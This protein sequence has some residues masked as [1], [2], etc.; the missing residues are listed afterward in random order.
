M[1]KFMRKN[2][3]FISIFLC[4]VLLPMVT[5]S[6]M[7]IDVSRIQNARVLV[8]SAGDLAMNAGMSEY[9]KTLQEMYG[10][11]ATNTSS[12][13]LE[14]ALANYFAKTIQGSIGTNN[15]AE[16]EYIQKFSQKFMQEIFSG[17]VDSD[18]NLVG[19][20]GNKIE[21]TNFMQMVLD[22]Q[23]DASKNFEYSCVDNSSPANPAVMKQQIVDY[24]KYKG[25]VSIS[26]NLLNKIGAMKDAKKQSEAIEKKLDYTK[27]L[28]D[29]TD[30]C[31]SAFK[32]V[33]GKDTDFDEEESNKGYNDYVKTYNDD[34]IADNKPFNAG[35]KSDSTPYK[36]IVNNMEKMTEFALYYT[37]AMIASGQSEKPSG[38]AG[39]GYNMADAGLKGLKYGDFKNLMKNEYKDCESGN[40]SD[41]DSCCKIFD[42]LVTNETNPNP[43]YSFLDSRKDKNSDKDSFDVTFNE[44]EFDKFIKNVTVKV[45]TEKDTK[46]KLSWLEN[47]DAK[48]ISKATVKSVEV[49]K[50]DPNISKEMIQEW[51]NQIAEAAKNAQYEDV[52]KADGD[53]F[54]FILNILDNK[55][56]NKRKYKDILKFIY[57]KKQIYDLDKSFDKCW[58][59][60]E[61]S[62]IEEKKKALKEKDVERYDYENSDAA[63]TQCKDI[64][65]LKKELE[66]YDIQDLS[67]DYDNKLNDF[68]EKNGIY[69]NYCDLL[70]NIDSD[71]KNEKVESVKKDKIITKL[72]DII[73]K[74]DDST[75]RTELKDIGNDSFNNTADKLYQALEGKKTNWETA[76]TTAE[77]AKDKAQENLTNDKRDRN[78]KIDDIIDQGNIY[79]SRVE[80]S[81]KALEKDAELMA[82]NEKGYYDKQLKKDVVKELAKQLD[83]IDRELKDF[84]EDLSDRVKQFKE[85][86]KP[87]LKAA[88]EEIDDFY[89][90]VCKCYYFA[91]K[92]EEALNKVS[93]HYDK[94]EDK[95]QKWQN[96][97]N[98]VQDNTEKAKMVS[99]AESTS[100]GLKKDDIENAKTA[101]QNRKKYYAELKEMLESIRFFDEG[102]LIDSSKTYNFVVTDSYVTN[103]YDKI[104]EH[105]KQNGLGNVAQDRRKSEKI[106]ID[107]VDSKSKE[108]VVGLN[109]N[110][111]HLLDSRPGG[112]E[113]K[114]FN[115]N[116]DISLV[117]EDDYEIKLGDMMNGFKT[118]SL[119]G[120]ESYDYEIFFKVLINIV[121]PKENNDEEAKKDVDQI[122][123]VKDDAIKDKGEKPKTTSSGGGSGGSVSGK[124]EKQTTTADD[125][126]RVK[127][128]ILANAQ[129]SINEYGANGGRCED[130]T[131]DAGDKRKDFELSD[132]K[133]NYSKNSKQAKESMKQAGNLLEGL[134]RLGKNVLQDAYLEEYFTEMFTCQTD[135]LYKN[136]VKNNAKMLNGVTIK[137]MYRND[138]AWYGGEIE[139]IIWGGKDVVSAK[140]KNEVAIYALRLVF[141]L[142][143]ACTAADIQ[144]FTLTAATAIAG[145]T[146]VG[147]PLV[148]FLLTV[149]LAAAESA[150]D[151]TKLKNGEN[152]AIY[153]NATTFICSPSGALQEGLK[154]VASCAISRAA[155]LAQDK[156]D[157]TIEDIANKGYQK[158]EEITDA[159]KEKLKTDFV[160]AQAENIKTIVKN[161]IATPLIDK[162]RPV[163]ILKD[164]AGDKFKG[165]V[166][167]KVKEAFA[168]INSSTAY[169]DSKSGIL[170]SFAEQIAEKVE[171]YFENNMNSLF[172]LNADNFVEFINKKIDNTIN[173]T[174]G[175]ING[176]L[177]KIGNEF[178]EELKQYKDKSVNKLKEL[179]AKSTVS[180]SEKLTNN[181]TKL[182][183]D[184]LG[185]I[186][187]VKKVDSSSSGCVT[188][189]YKEY[190]KIFVL[191]GLLNE[192]N[193][194]SMLKR[195]A[196]LCQANVRY[197]GEKF[198]DDADENF[199]MVKVN[200]VVTIHAKV[201][202]GTLF[203]WGVTVSE[204]GMGNDTSV[205]ISKLGGHSVIID[206]QGVN[207]Y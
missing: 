126:I 130:N 191:V 92:S 88:M 75:F 43:A 55:D 70:S 90:C 135:I 116:P 32:Y 65:D 129:K 21:F 110:R 83:E 34:Y 104:L 14:D 128:D 16:D 134:S 120:E 169:L 59:D 150:L 38:N 66:K 196:A 11:F 159:E 132:K 165:E 157:E 192:D 148:Q 6:T 131:N 76:K 180:V 36:N 164:T 40:Q 98:A 145:W 99:D 46:Y 103:V 149:G 18:G 171:E 44:T 4:L 58:N 26:M 77:K 89:V 198:K 190:C 35:L 147:V 71:N 176:E 95:L 17:T 204:N 86:G 41:I 140:L 39:V 193:Q 201:K 52:S 154:T 137:D 25:P 133:K 123:Q 144:E 184:K 12:K 53:T 185:G 121:K 30:P 106:K 9:N 175:V 166:E 115:W 69:K 42:K 188:L 195:C 117:K 56:E 202:L 7:V 100:T 125:T 37:V 31:E 113:P 207:A 102:K 13:E 142:I 63:K 62:I 97:A 73:N 143:Y 178:K 91:G 114:A 1:M 160:D 19:K 101:A 158:I 156:M 22:A 124:V 177:D 3:G 54:D 197:P 57:Y 119:T 49:G 93:Q 2:K 186:E 136:V 82:K 74:G 112:K 84:L 96:S 29:I 163:F 45:E 5:F 127:K 168:S 194:A 187:E 15:L 151:V 162:L 78:K 206:Y 24:M 60:Y 10:I 48:Y 155:K 139:Y 167:S 146:V 161:L 118:V 205:N 94:I 105:G 203:P 28:D 200:T 81:K 27:T 152:V 47:D 87:Y 182:I 111:G 181:A 172:G 109:G 179:T 64:E 79:D 72:N 108:L 61:T 170:K 199:E 20:D 33:Y 107:A 80:E 68:N 183:D 138:T 85:H 67:D 23:E 141:N 174:K 189:N 51:K 153:K 122:K 8:T 50:D 173:E